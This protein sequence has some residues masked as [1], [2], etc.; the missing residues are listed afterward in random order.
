LSGHPPRWSGAFHESE[1]LDAKAPLDI[2]RQA[3]QSDG[4]MGLGRVEL[5]TSHLS[6]TSL[7]GTHPAQHTKPRESVVC[8]FII[9]AA[10]GRLRH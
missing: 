7:C 5:A 8:T 10:A 9:G 2:R 4:N 3:G 6:E 1:R